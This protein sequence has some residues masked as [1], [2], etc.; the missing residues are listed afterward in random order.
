MIDGDMTAESN[1]EIFCFDDGVLSHSTS[2]PMT[3]IY[4]PPLS[5]FSN[6]GDKG[7]L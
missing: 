5:P 3:T 7:G 6:R 1:G 2:I 4:N